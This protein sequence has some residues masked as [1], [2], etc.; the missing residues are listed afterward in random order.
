LSL[1]HDIKTPLTI[2]DGYIEEIEDNIVSKEE[3]PKVLAILKKETAYLNELS[4]EVISYV[5]SKDEVTQKETLFLKKFLHAEV[6]PLLRVTKEVELKCEISK[7]DCI[8]FNPMALKKILINLL[9]NA[10]KYTS[11]GTITVK[12]HANKLM[13]EDT[14]FGINIE[15]AERI[16]DPFFCLDESRN[17]EKS[18]FGLGLSIARNLAQRNGY[19]L[20]L[21]NTYVSGSRFILE[22]SNGE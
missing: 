11:S 1:S 6:Y 16:F 2:I 13:I 15:D 22:E 14:G 10:I 5:Q 4:S 19:R 18:G 8:E 7:T 12:L 20:T 9:H 17:R 21:D 3:M